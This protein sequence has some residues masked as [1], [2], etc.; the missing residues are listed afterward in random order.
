MQWPAIWQERVFTLT[1]KD[2]VW[3]KKSNPTEKLGLADMSTLQWRAGGE[4]DPAQVLH[5]DAVEVSKQRTRV[6]MLRGGALHTWREAI[7][8]V[9]VPPPALKVMRAALE[10]DADPAI[11]G[12]EVRLRIEASEPCRVTDVSFGDGAVAASV[13]PD[14]EAASAGGTP[15]HTAYVAT[16]VLQEDDQKDVGPLKVSTVRLSERSLGRSDAPPFARLCARR[17]ES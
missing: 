15:K 5:F 16:A 9:R 11:I 1:G 13:V 14:G 12:T 4:T 8:R 7:D 6:F 10:A 2:L 17:E 3:A